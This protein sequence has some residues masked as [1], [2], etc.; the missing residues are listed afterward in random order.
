M[1][2]FWQW[3]NTGAGGAFLLPILLCGY[4]ALTELY[5]YAIR[6]M[7]WQ[8]SH[9]MYAAGTMPKD[10][11]VWQHRYLPWRRRKVFGTWPAA[12]NRRG[13]PHVVVLKPDHYRWCD[14]MPLSMFMN[15]YK[16][17]P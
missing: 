1:I 17:L 5:E 15:R 13:Y 14:D 4:F 16:E 7:Y 10:E 2:A 8:S 11:T 12:N 6:R 9:T 3:L